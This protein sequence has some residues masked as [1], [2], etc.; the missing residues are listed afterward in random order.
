MSSSKKTDRVLELEGVAAGDRWDV[1]AA[2]A[3][4]Q[5]TS[6]SCA[7]GAL[8]SPCL[9]LM[10]SLGLFSWEQRTLKDVRLILVV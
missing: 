3:G 9:L 1:F 10:A 4:K 8:L 2:G 7:A 5:D 6:A